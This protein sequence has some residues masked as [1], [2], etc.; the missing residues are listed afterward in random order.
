MVKEYVHLGCGCKPTT[1]A[2]TDIWAAI[3]SYKKEWGD[4]TT[5]S[6]VKGLDK[7][8][9]EEEGIP[10]GC[11]EQ[12]N[13]RTDD[14]AGN[15]YAH[16]GDPEYRRE[17]CSQFDT[18]FGPTI[19]GKVVAHKMGATVFKHLQVAQY[20]HYWKARTGAGGWA[21]NADVNGHAAACRRVLKAS[22]NS[23][24]SSS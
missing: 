16:P 15:A 17:Y 4:Q 21:Q 6:W 10:T 2:D 22:P 3:V 14:D 24:S 23:V 5:V 20:L 12:E 18:I 11:R 1:A 9:A 7:D 13:K 19:E 8:H